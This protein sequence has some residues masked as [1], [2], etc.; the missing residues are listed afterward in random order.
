MIFLLWFFFRLFWLWKNEACGTTTVYAK[1]TR[2]TQ[3]EQQ[4]GS[5][6]KR[7]THICFAEF[8]FCFSSFDDK[9]KHSERETA[10]QRS[11][12]TSTKETCIFQ[13]RCK[14]GVFFNKRFFQQKWV[15]R[16]HLSSHACAVWIVVSF[17]F[18]LC[19]FACNVS[20]S[21]DATQKAK[22]CNKKKS[23][24]AFFFCAFF[25]RAW[26]LCWANRAA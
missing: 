9:N 25:L 3:R 20:V 2:A 17:F 7:A 5:N 16:L 15:V 12:S 11:T 22:K 21:L 24:F 14:K 13:K 8:L 4:Q 26:S 6:N 1:R 23:F 18:L 19:T 10:R